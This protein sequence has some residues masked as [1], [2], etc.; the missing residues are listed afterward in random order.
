MDSD[1]IEKTIAI[2]ELFMEDKQLPERNIDLELTFLK[3]QFEDSINSKLN[4]FTAYNYLGFYLIILMTHIE[5]LII[6]DVFKIISIALYSIFFPLL[7]IASTSKARKLPL[8]K[9]AKVAINNQWLNIF[10]I[11]SILFILLMILFFKFFKLYIELS[12][13]LM[14]LISLFSIP[15]FAFFLNWIVKKASKYFNPYWFE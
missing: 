2:N 12:M 6:G 5:Y 14:L 1:I 8:E 3:N 11:S 13:N 4:I 7:W 10:F 15:A 9:R